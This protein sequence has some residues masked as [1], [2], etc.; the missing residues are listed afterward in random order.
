MNNVLNFQTALPFAHGQNPN[1]SAFIEQAKNIAADAGL[2]WDMQVNAVG[3]AAKGM[4]WDLRRM[5]NDGRPKTFILRTFAECGDAL[6]SM[7]RRG[8]LS[9]SESVGT[10]SAA[11]QD[12]IKAYTVEHVLVRKKGIAYIGSAATAL[13]FV[14]TISRKEP[15]E[16]TAEDLRLAC[17]ISD[18]LQP[19]RGRTIVILGFISSLV[20]PLHLFN[21]CPLGGLL[22]RPEKL[23][24]G[25]ARFAQTTKKLVKTLAERKAEE[26]LPERRAFWELVRIVFTEKPRT[27][28]DALR[29]AMIKV[30]L[31]TGLRVGEVAHLPLDWK[32][33]RAYVDDSGRPAG[34]LG[35]ISECSRSAISQKSKTATRSTRK[36]SSCPT[37]S[38]TRLK[39]R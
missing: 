30:L 27:I 19:S 32:R 22:T 13:R 16:T 31:F 29:F 6:Q 21:A 7:Q 1:F 17:E 23:R 37:C 24:A 18:E 35:G 8:I 11:W 14:A 39:P 3:N 4:E 36:R 34:E 10:V 5:A 25:R 28:N 9:R 2:H 33:T 38:A 12:L 15:W 26:K 20:D